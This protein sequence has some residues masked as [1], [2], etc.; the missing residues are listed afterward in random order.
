MASGVDESPSLRIALVVPVL[1]DA[2]SL[3]RLLPALARRDDIDE[4]VVVDASRSQPAANFYACVPPAVSR[5]VR[6]IGASHA[7]R[8]RQMNLGADSTDADVFLFLHADSRLPEDDLRP[9]LGGVVPIP[10][11]GRFDV[12]LDDGHG[13]ARMIAWAMNRRSRLTGIATG[14]QGIFVH[15][16][17]WLQCGGYRDLPLMEDI[18]LSRR[19][20][21][22]AR[23]ACLDARMTT[24]ARRWRQR[25]VW[26]TIILMWRLRLYYWLGVDPQRLARMYRDE[27]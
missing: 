23:P 9:L 6:F 2:D 14:D 11:W 24:S 25:G 21:R 1:D 15:R 12:R 5:R 3:A 19:L 10:G 17:R 8:A 13:W 4:V 20:K 7:G 26:R 27:R 18:D 22:L 16:D